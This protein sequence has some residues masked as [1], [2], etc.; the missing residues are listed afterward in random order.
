MWDRVSFILKLFI[1][2]AL[3][4]FHKIGNTSNEICLPSQMVEVGKDD[5]AEDLKSL[6]DDTDVELTSEVKAVL[7]WLIFS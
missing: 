5:D 4:V 1:T 7:L 6:S 3:L 2:F